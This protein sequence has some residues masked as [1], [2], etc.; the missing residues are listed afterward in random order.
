[1]IKA[2][3]WVHINAYL[4]LALDLISNKEFTLF[5]KIMLQDLHILA[6]L[7]VLF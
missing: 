5:T 7:E 3:D 6:L 2:R 4:D 1:M